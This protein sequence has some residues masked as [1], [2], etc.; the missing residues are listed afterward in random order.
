MMH[1][2]APRLSPPPGF[3]AGFMGG[4]VGAALDLTGQQRIVSLSVNAELTDRLQGDIPFVEQVTLGGDVLMRGFLRGR[5]VDRSALVATLEYAWPIWVYLDGVRS[6]QKRGS[7]I[8]VLVAAGTDPI[9]EGTHISSF[10][11]SIGTHHGL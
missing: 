8:E 4:L 3:G 6:N 7:G 1:R 9:D 2:P 5:L 10:R 11:F